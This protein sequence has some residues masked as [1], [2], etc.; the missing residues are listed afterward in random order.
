LK[1]GLAV[2][3]PACLIHSAEIF[4]YELILEEIIVTA[5]KREQSIQDVPVS[6]T[7]FNADALD[8]FD[9]NDVLGISRT[10]P[11]V[12][13]TPQQ[14]KMSNNPLRI[15]GVGASGTN[16]AF[17]G[18]VGVYVD[19][20]YRS[21]AG[22]VLSSMNDIDSVEILR[23]PQG[24]L[25]G[26]NTSAGALTMESNEP[27]RIFTSGA[28]ISVGDY[29]QRHLQ[30]FISG[31]ASDTVALRFSVLREQRDGFINSPET[32]I[33]YGDVNTWSYKFQALYESSAQFQARLIADYTTTDEKCCHGNTVRITDD[34]LDAL[35]YQPLA[36]SV[37]FSVIN[38]ANPFAYQNTLNREGKD[39]VDDAGVLL[40]ASWALERST[41]RSI[42]S[43]RKWIYDQPGSDIDFGPV[44]LLELSELYD[45]KTLSQE[46]TWSGG[47]EDAGPAQRVDFVTGL[48]FSRETIDYYRSL[49]EGIH[50]ISNWITLYDVIL[51]ALNF[52]DPM[53][54]DFLPRSIL[55]TPGVDVYN[56][57]FDHTDKV[58]ALYG[59]F[60]FL[61]ND[62]W[63]IV[64]G[65][66]YSHE[67]KRAQHVVNSRSDPFSESFGFF[68]LGASTGGRNFDETHVDKEFT[69]NLALQ[70]F[71]EAGNMLFASY[72]RGYKAGG[73]S[74]NNDAGGLVSFALSPTGF[75]PYAD[76]SYLP[77]FV[78]AYEVGYKSTQFEG[79]GQTS[80][81]AFYQDY[82]DIQFQVFT[83]TEFLVFNASTAYSKG[84]ELVNT[85]QINENLRSSLAVTWL[86]A[87]YG[88]GAEAP[89]NLIGRDLDHA[90]SLASTAS[91][92]YER[93]VS[94]GL[95][96]YANLNW[97]FMGKHYTDTATAVQQDSYNLVN[98][99]LGLAPQDGPWDVSLWCRNCTDA[100]YI[101]A[102]FA[103]PF[104]FG[105][106]EAAYIGA[107]KTVGL[108]FHYRY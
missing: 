19:G 39:I 2:F 4:A 90:S 11:S 82:T 41:L 27:S 56:G 60:T 20:V 79:R 13:F 18:S 12:S 29:D 91:L 17:E 58:S 9:I 70:Y 28:G 84:I 102:S 44:D 36:N 62:N 45:I 47:F 6:V 76:P 23:G 66:N 59:H 96:A 107:P 85:F 34:E 33:D 63:S 15:R 75:T 25:F 68:V 103:Q 51:G 53:S 21:R 16:P 105:G 97:S 31:P 65:L 3:V 100:E 77:E 48:Y 89:A 1:F 10:S 55:A 106:A 64:A 40:D 30:A 46:F 93:P 14:S 88:K 5:Q 87:A 26:K 81:S 8:N 72:A 32:G 99:R 104:Y 80:I 50:S 94:S 37:G 24:T 83:G 86:D 95:K 74:L 92:F 35:L 98:L 101:I 61:F 78:D 57:R 54:P 49:Q 22:M 7:A 38:P 71:T 42:S 43:W 69:G 73:I 67:K 108:S 52:T